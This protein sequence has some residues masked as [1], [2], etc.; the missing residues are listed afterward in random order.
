[1][2]SPIDSHWWGATRE[3]PAPELAMPE[4]MP[5]EV[6]GDPL[7]GR[8]HRLALWEQELREEERRLGDW[9]AWLKSESPFTPAWSLPAQPVTD[10]LRELKRDR[11][12]SD[13]D[14]ETFAA[15][16][17]LDP[18][19]TRQLLHGE[20]EELDLQQIA[21]LCEALKC[22][23]YDLWTPDEARTIL[24]AYGPEL[25]PRL[26]EPL[27]A[28]RG[29]V[30]D[31][32]VDRRSAQQALDVLTTSDLPGQGRRLPAA[33]ELVVTC[34]RQAGVLQIDEGGAITKVDDHS[35]PAIDGLEYHLAFRQL[36]PERVVTA[37]LSHTA[38]DS[39][40][41]AG[42]DADPAL[43]EVAAMLRQEPQLR[44]AAMIRFAS[45]AGPSEQWIGWDGG[46][47]TWQTWDDPR[48]Y[49]PGDPADVLAGISGDEHLPLRLADDDDHSSDLAFDTVSNI[50]V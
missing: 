25:W 21:E 42:V 33:T 9:A 32:F 17:G 22:S 29:L 44:G 16:F 13:G 2:S 15:G 27:D 10:A 40:P 41:G 37:P 23:P 14:V 30:D 26:I 19:D 46:S 36:E 7:A 8:E 28:G 35:Q 50:E 4:H 48:A 39:G 45:T 6:S 24:H 12:L 5:T 34:Y 47:A 3:E 18:T 49:F 43:V 31:T 20:V 38:F 1:M 11:Y